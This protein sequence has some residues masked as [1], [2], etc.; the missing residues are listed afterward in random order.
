MEFIA[1]RIWQLEAWLTLSIKVEYSVIIAVF[2]LPYWQSYALTSL[3]LWFSRQA[4]RQLSPLGVNHMH[5][6]SSTSFL[7]S[8]FLLNL[9]I[10]RVFGSLTLF[11]RNWLSKAKLRFRPKKVGITWPRLAVEKHTVNSIDFFVCTLMDDN[12]LRPP[13]KQSLMVP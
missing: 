6:V 9:V 7:P 3:L 5:M 8:K 13:K 2:R 12:R 11:A 1:I 10:T 4:V